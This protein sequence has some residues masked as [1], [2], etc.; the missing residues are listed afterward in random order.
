MCV[1]PVYHS[2]CVLILSVSVPLLAPP[3]SGWALTG[4]PAVYHLVGMDQSKE[5]R[6]KEREA[7]SE[8]FESLASDAH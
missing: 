2:A 1:L 8:D 7:F 5:Q 4:G 6:L 3:L